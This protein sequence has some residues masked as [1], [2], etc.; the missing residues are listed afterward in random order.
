[1]GKFKVIITDILSDSYDIERAVLSEADADLT[2]YDALSGAGLT[3]A[4][5]DADGILC[6]LAKISAAHIEAMRK[7]KVISRYGIGY[8]NV[9]A[10]ACA[11]RGVWLANVPDYCQKEV[12]EHTIALMMGIARQIPQ[13]NARIRKGVWDSG[14]KDRII[15]LWGKTAGL[16]GFGSIPRTMAPALQAL[17]MAVISY[18]PYVDAEKMGALGVR[19]AELGELLESSDFLCVHLPYNEQTRGMIGDGELARMKEGAIVVNTAR[20]GIVDEAALTRAVAA[21][22][23]SGAG[24]DVYENEPLSGDNAL[25][26]Y[27][28]VV[29][30]DHCAWNSAESLVELKTKCAQN[31]RDVLLGG[32][33]KY[34]V[35]SIG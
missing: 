24:L 23:I 27:D 35:V 19:K 33:P 22:H 29:L 10:A 34:P 31:V 26:R 9:D 3:E 13:K 1:M 2:A 28:N 25:L 18:D 17:G 32:K 7:C 16:L 11:R 21:G 30:T 4:A 6:N 14:R 5:R 15:R 20:G 12:C 8:D